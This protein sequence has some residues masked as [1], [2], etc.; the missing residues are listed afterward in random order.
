MAC[1]GEAASSI[2]RWSQFSHL[3]AS[4]SKGSLLMNPTVFSGSRGNR[5]GEHVV[6]CCQNVSRA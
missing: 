4:N 3:A 2:F 5:F 6:L 1:G